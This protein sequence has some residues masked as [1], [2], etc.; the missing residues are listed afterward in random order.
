VSKLDGTD[1]TIYSTSNSDLVN[2][3]SWGLEIKD[4]D[5]VYFATVSGVS[6]L[7]TA[8]A[9]PTAEFSGSPT[10]GSAP[11]DVDF[12]DS[13]TGDVTSWSWTFGDGGTSTAE[14]PSHQY[15]SAD[16]YTVALTVTG[17][18]GSDNES[19][20]DYIS[21]S[22]AGPYSQRVNCGGSSHQDAASRTW[23]ADKTY[24]ADSWGYVDGTGETTADAIAGTTEDELYQDQRE[25]NFEYKFDLANGD[26]DVTLY[27]AEIEKTQSLHRKFDVTVEGSLE[28]NDYDIYTAAGGHDVVTSETFTDVTVSDGTLNIVFDDVA[29]RA[30]C[31]AIYVRDA[32]TVVAE[33]GA[34]PTS[35][36]YPLDVTFADYSAGDI[37]SWSWTFGDGGTSTSQNPSHQYTSAGDYDVSLT[38]SDGTNSDDTTKTD[39]IT[40]ST[41]PAPVAAFSGTPTSGTTPLDVDFTDASTGSITSWSWTFGDGGTSTVEDPSHQYTTGGDYTVVLTVTGPGGSDNETKTDYITANQPASPDFEADRTSGSAP[42][43]VS[44]TDKTTGCADTWKYD[45]QNNDFDDWSDSQTGNTTWTYDTPGT[46]SVKQTVRDCESSDYFYETK[47]NYITVTA[48]SEPNADFSGSP[49]SGDAALQVTFTN[50]TTGTFNEYVWNLGDGTTSTEYAPVHTYGTAGQ[51]SV[52]LDVNGPQGSSAEQKY[53]YIEVTQPGAPTAAFTADDTQ[54]TY[55]HTVNFTDLST[56]S[57]T[58][59]EWDF[60]EGDSSTAE[61]PQY[62]Y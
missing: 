47:T 10:S 37:T 42:L 58:S 13:S 4:A 55:P 44:F 12:T 38:V 19:K 48:G 6:W 9:A 26:Y 23:A 41:P 11:L 43:L 36:S 35:G 52:S 39:Y 21:V 27:F 51:Y 33:F 31:A 15:S 20:T 25:Q 50:L 40:A 46:Y 14:D 30:M 18:G 24:A 29:D 22:D 53:F 2:N 5:N 59:W 60:G 17:P 3:V 61:D 28:L 7:E 32:G 16:D 45:F 1:F 8:A 54:G 34:S 49:T 56:G 62:T 57:I